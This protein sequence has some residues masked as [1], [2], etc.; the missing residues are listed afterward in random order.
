[1]A[2]QISRRTLLKTASFAGGMSVLSACNDVALPG[3]ST[4]SN[5]DGSTPPPMVMPDQLPSSSAPLQ[6]STSG[7]DFVY[8]I[9]YSDEEWRSRLTPAEYQILREGATEPRHSHRFTQTT[10]VGVYHCQGCDLPIYASSQKVILDIGWVFFRH[11]LPDSVLLGVDGV[12]IEAHCRRCAGHLGHVLY[13]ETEV[14]HCI[15]G[16]ALNFEAT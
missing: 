13:V 11:S 1:M 6:R 16:T 7:T 8:E 15:N 14:L 9:Q 2:D 12:A 3:L 4:A 5:T 10:D